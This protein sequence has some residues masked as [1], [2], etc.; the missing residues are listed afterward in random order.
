MALFY[1]KY[2]NYNNRRLKREDTL[3]GYSN[4]LVYT[5]VNPN[6]NPGDGVSTEITVARYQHAFESEA[7]HVIY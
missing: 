3:Q 1:Y 2:N 5:E 6:F 4:Y 7:D